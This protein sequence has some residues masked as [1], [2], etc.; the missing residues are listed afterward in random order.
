[1]KWGGLD[2]ASASYAILRRLTFGNHLANGGVERGFADG[3][4]GEA[5]H[6][7]L[8]ALHH[9]LT[10]SGHQQARAG[11]VY[12]PPKIRKGLWGVERIL[13]VIGA[14]EPGSD[15]CVGQPWGEL[16]HRPL[17]PTRALQARA[18][19]TPNNERHTATAALFGTQTERTERTERTETSRGAARQCVMRFA[20]DWSCV[21][22][23]RDEA[24][25]VQR[26]G[27]QH[28]RLADQGH[29]L[30]ARAHARGPTHTQ[31]SKHNNLQA[32]SELVIPGNFYSY[33]MFPLLSESRRVEARRVDLSRHP[34]RCWCV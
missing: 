3:I 31:T 23:H 9:H 4:H 18:T 13:A 6:D 22:A 14:G 21:V 30:S 26:A 12:P 29:R 20:L 16:S 15:L 25:R 33:T 28:G 2:R 10:A 5:V 7:G 17:K 1:M 11:D 32:F 27:E 24:L 19:K 34:A 8:S